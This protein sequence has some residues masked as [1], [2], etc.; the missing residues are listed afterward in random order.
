MPTCQKC[1]Q[2]WSWRDTQKGIM[3]FK[4]GINCPY[5]GETQYQTASSLRRTNLVGLAPLL[6]LPL[7]IMFDSWFWTILIIL[8]AS[9]A[10]LSII[11][12]FLKLSNEE[13]PMW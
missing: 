5:C 6:A 11:P 2:E 1:N 4:K 13:E 9:L 10:H 12:F 8:M 7:V 3:H